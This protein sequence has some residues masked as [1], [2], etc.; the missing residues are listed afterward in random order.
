MVVNESFSHV[1]FWSA[2]ASTLILFP[3]FAWGIFWLHAGKPALNDSVIEFSQGEFSPQ[4]N[5][6]WQTIDL[7]HDWRQE[8]LPVSHAWYRFRFNMEQ[9]PVALSSLYFP[10]LSQNLAVYLNGVEIGNGGSLQE[11]VT[12]NWPRPLIFPVAPEFLRKGEN[13]LLLWLVSDPEG[14]GLLKQFYLGDRAILQSAWLKRN[15]LKVT[16]VTASAVGLVVLALMLFGITLRRRSDTQYAWGG[17][18][19]IGLAGHSVPM[20]MHQIP[21]SSFI[22]EWWQHMCIGWT[23]VAIL[24]FNFRFLGQRHGKIESRAA[25]AVALFSFLSLVLTWINR[26]DLYFAWGSAVWGSLC[27]LLATVPMQ[28]LFRA[29]V[30]DKDPQKITLLGAGILLFFFGTHD[31]LF[32]LGWIARENGYLI[33]YASPLVALVFTCILFSRFVQT[34]SEV[35]ALNN[36]LEQRVAEKSAEL[37]HTHIMLREMERANVLAQERER[38]NRDM[39]DGLGGYLANALAIA[40]TTQ[41]AQSNLVSTLRDATEEMRLMIDSAEASDGDIGMVLG[42]ARPRLERH[43]QSRGFS[44][45][46][47]IEDTETIQSMGP[48]NAMQLIRIVQEG[49]TNA[50]K[51]SGGDCVEVCLRIVDIDCVLVEVS[52][53]GVCNALFRERGNGVGNIMTRA[54]QLGGSA[55]FISSG[56]LGGLTVEISIPVAVNPVQQQSAALTA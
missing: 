2:L 31:V 49:V 10:V 33:H 52:D 35:E 40:E 27:L 56:K 55:E 7:T 3:A 6:N 22:W 17:L 46:W 19:L 8:K 16:T 4:D 42:T 11:P 15:T 24:I 47:K 45:I 37:E 51:H 48:A 39:H 12:R 44:L 34:S 21:V 38:F 41:G 1:R 54:R 14:R 20:L 43:L 18:A 9:A 25:A 32:V 30:A 26:E 53:N 29:C 50:C 5:L 36:S 13:E 23:T 28:S